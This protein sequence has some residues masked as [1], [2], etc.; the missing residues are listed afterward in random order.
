[1]Q[2]AGDKG[3]V[4]LSSMQCTKVVCWQLHAHVKPIL[5]A[6]Y[7]CCTGWFARHET[8]LESVRVMV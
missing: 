3:H 1:V 4:Q 2:E 7:T 8:Q 5:A 6:L